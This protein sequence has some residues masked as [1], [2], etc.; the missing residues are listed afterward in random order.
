MKSTTKTVRLQMKI[1]ID[2]KYNSFLQV[3]I[4]LPGNVVQNL[5]LYD[6]RSVYSEKAITRGG[7]SIITTFIYFQPLTLTMAK[8]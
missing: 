5:C 4:W 1:S 7:I 2:R 8:F 6:M 3:S